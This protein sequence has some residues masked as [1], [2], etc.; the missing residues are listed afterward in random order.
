MALASTGKTAD[1]EAT[2]KTYLSKTGAIP[3]DTGYGQNTARAVFK[4]GE[5]FLNAR[6]AAARGDR[7]RAIAELRA[8]VAAEDTL[9]Y[10]EPPGWY[11]P[12]S[13]EAL[14]GALLLDKQYA[15]AERVF[16]EDLRRNR[17]N[18]RSLFGLAESL[19]AQG[20]TREADLV[21]REF[22]RAWKD[23]DTRLKVEDL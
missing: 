13:R 9:A 2:L 21:R 20:K 17:R 14:G 16:R 12:L 3:A 22:D 19:K 10:D 7:K 4:I 5:H 6:L 23:A 18:G 8:A 11:H 1:A 15:E